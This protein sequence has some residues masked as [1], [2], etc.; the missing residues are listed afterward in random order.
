LDLLH[1]GHV[2]TL[3]AARALGD[4]LIVCLNSDRGVRALKGP[5]RPVVTETDRTRVL[6]ALSC[7][8]AVVLFDE[9]TPVEVLTAL[10]PD[11][12]VKGGDYTGDDLPEQEHVARWG[13]QTVIVPYLDGH[14]TTHLITTMA[15]RA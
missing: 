8:D 12:W 10:R 1:P 11:L 3:E 15:G 13:G 9:E 2:A 6:A 4:C 7:V 14:S 5:D